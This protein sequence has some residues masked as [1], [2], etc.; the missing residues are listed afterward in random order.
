MKIKNIVI[1]AFI[2]LMSLASFGQTSKFHF[3]LHCSPNLSWIKPDVEEILYEG[4]GTRIGVS[5]GAIFE[6]FFTP[7]V[8]LVTGVNVIYTGGHLKYPYVPADLVGDTGTLMRCYR[9][10]YLEIPLMIKGS[11]GELLGNFSF[12]GQFGIG[13]GVN[14]KAKADDEYQSETNPG[15]AAIVKNNINASK[16]ISFFRESMIIGIGSQYKLG[17]SAIVQAGF[18]FCNGFTDI[19]TENTTIKPIIKEKARSNFVE[20]NIAF[21]FAF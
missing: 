21:L 13:T 8:G 2:V 19:L 6:Y 7:N 14:L 16:D 17:K 3:G 1:A 10:Q 5:Y 20:L 9:L 18:N 15:T 4:N 12:Y 11:T